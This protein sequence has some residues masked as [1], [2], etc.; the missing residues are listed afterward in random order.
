MG[1]VRHP[2]TKMAD[3]MAATYHIP[4]RGHSNLVIFYWIS[5]KFHIWIAFY[6]TLIQAR[7]WVLSDE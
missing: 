6:Q 5:F 1:F 7:I 3:K 2:I 4:C